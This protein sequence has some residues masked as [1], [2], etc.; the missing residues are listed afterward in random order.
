M[1]YLILLMSLVVGCNETTEEF[2]TVAVNFDISKNESGFYAG[3]GFVVVNHS[4]HATEIIWDFGDGYICH[5]SIC[6]HT[7]QCKG[8]YVL[9]LTAC[10]PGSCDSI[11]LGITV[12]DSVLKL[13][14][15]NNSK[16]WNLSQWIDKNRRPVDFDTCS[17]N[18]SFTVNKSGEHFMRNNG[19]QICGTDTFQCVYPSSDDHGWFEIKFDPFNRNNQILI[20][21]AMKEVYTINLAYDQL[22]LRSN[23][24]GDEFF[25]VAE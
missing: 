16:T 22:I 25:Y 23:L 17:C 3:E 4:V 13:F 5:D 6:Q 7:Y 14:T 15:D 1:K 12:K 18:Y 8:N 11:K 24:S 21:Q 10:N 19:R 20:G 2:P 9:T